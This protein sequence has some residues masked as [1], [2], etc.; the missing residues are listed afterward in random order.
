M[1]VHGFHVEMAALQTQL[2][3]KE[4]VLQRA[5]SDTA[6][7]DQERAAAAAR[8]EEATQAVFSLEKQLRQVQ[9]SLEECEKAKAAVTERLTAAEARCEG[10][11][12]G[13]L[14]PQ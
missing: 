6:V 7:L 8:A 13:R 2:A 4:A 1:E 3:E 14:Q 5:L 11:Q 10:L 9:E 12:V